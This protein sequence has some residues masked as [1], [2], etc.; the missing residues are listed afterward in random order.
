MHVFELN[1]LYVKLILFAFFCKHNTQCGSPLLDRQRNPLDTLIEVVPDNKC[2]HPECNAS[3]P[4][5]GE[6]AKH[7]GQCPWR[8]Y[9]CLGTALK[10]WK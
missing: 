4:N 9:R 1:S 8:P 3:A 6:L 2:P 10:I 7:I 5:I